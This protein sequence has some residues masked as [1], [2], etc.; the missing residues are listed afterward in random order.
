MAVNDGQFT[1]N[2]K[3]AVQQRY[4]STDECQEIHG[5]MRKF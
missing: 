3:M 1:Y 2:K 5:Q 4:G